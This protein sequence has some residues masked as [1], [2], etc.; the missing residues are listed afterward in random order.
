MKIGEI[1]YKISSNSIFLIWSFPRKKKCSEHMDIICLATYDVAQKDIKILN[2]F[3]YY[4]EWLAN[5]AHACLL[6]FI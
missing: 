4:N 6:L 2:H 3:V 5:Y 1:S